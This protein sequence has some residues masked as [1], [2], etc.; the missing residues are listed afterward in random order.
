MPAIDPYF[1]DHIKAEHE[2]GNSNFNLRSSM[3]NT[4]LR[5]VVSTISINRVATKFNKSFG[6]KAQAVI[7][8]IQ[9]IGNYTMNGQILVLPIKGVGN[10]NLTLTDVDALIDLRGDYFDKDGETYVNVTNFKL[11]LTPKH[12]YFL[13]ENVFNGDAALSETINS[14]MNENWELVANTLVPGYELKLGDRF[15]KVANKFFDVIPLNYIFPE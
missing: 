14:F 3:T 2:S 8:N 6:L 9:L 10:A 7:K 11:K 4:E 15:Q 13:F 1:I 12:A 5:G